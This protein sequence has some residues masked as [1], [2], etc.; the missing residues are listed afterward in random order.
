MNDDH[1]ACESHLGHGRS[2]PGVFVFA[3]ALAAGTACSS[4]NSSTPADSGTSGQDSGSLDAGLPASDGGGDASPDGGTSLV[5]TSPQ[6]T[7][8][9]PIPAN[10]TCAGI[11]TS[12]ELD[13]T[14]GPAGTQSYAL[15]VT[16]TSTLMRQGGPI[17]HWVVWDIPP[18]VRQLPASLPG[19]PV[20]TTPVSAKQV[21]LR[22]NP[23]AGTTVNG[24][25]GPCPRGN[26]HSY[27][28]E[29]H[30]L[31]VATLP[32]VTTTSTSADVK[33]AVVG[34]ATSSHSLAHA[35]LTGT[36][37]ASPPSDAGGQ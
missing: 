29:I 12:P 6:F 24:Y 36:S 14:A 31:D 10:N 27:Q 37:N 18:T 20:L 4:S 34:G 19:D 16:D 9:Q 1:S 25:F 21:D 32:G 5:L 13:W 15:V 28:F 23:E 26:L 33:A 8:G 22:T 2:G 35:D 3:C 11:N 17:I 7:D 30:A